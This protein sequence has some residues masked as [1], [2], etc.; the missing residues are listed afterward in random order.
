MQNKGMKT[1]GLLFLF[2]FLLA[3]FLFIM[4]ITKIAKS[5]YSS[6]SLKEVTV[7]EGDKKRIDFVDQNGKVTVAAN[8]GYATRIIT[9]TETEE[10]TEYFDDQGKPARHY[11][12]SFAVRRVYNESEK[13]IR[14]VYLGAESKPIRTIY[15]YAMEDRVYND[16]G[17]LEYVYYYD[18]DGNPATTYSYGHG[19]RNEYDENGNVCRITYLNISGEPTKTGQGYASVVRSYY[20]D[21]SPYSDK[22]KDELYFD[23]NGDPVSLSL[24]EYG[25]HREYNEIGWNSVITYLDVN[26]NP[27]ANNQGYTTVVRTFHADNS[28][29]TERY[30]D[31]DGK[32]YALAAGQYGTKTE[33]GRTV[34]LDENGN[35]RFDLKNL[36]YNHSRLVI[37]AAIILVVMASLVGQR[38]NWILLVLYLAVIAYVTLMFRENDEG[39]IRL[40]PFWSY[41]QIIFNSGL[42]ADIFRNIWLF[43][44]LGAILYRLYP[45][46][47]VLLVPAVL[48]AAIEAVQYFAGIG[49]CELDDMV[50]N[51]LG[52]L[53]GYGSERLLKDAVHKIPGRRRLNNAKNE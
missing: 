29:E 50:S 28:I 22:V 6:P 2:L 39:R 40:I 37:P 23:E 48:S 32:P 12:G 11:N 36:L 13:R 47:T 19:Y 15:G 8:I 46:W 21:E 31:A 43:V 27:A 7:Q 30:Y 53:I 44:P 33:E 17:R 18:P 20:S 49:F 52:G 35:E 45:R 38:G 51:V 24:G 9:H 26:G 14:T 41:R 42:R 5:Q 34:Y 1:G 10:L 25:V 4:P 3:S 16:A